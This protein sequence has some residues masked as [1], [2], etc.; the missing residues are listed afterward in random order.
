LPQ[1]LGVA[2]AIA[3]FAVVVVCFNKEGKAHFTFLHAK[4]GLAVFLLMLLQP[5]NAVF[6]PH[7]PEP[8]GG[9]PPVRSLWELLHKKMGYACLLAAWFNIILAF[10]LP[11][12]QTYR[13]F[14]TAVQVL[15]YCAACTYLGVGLSFNYG[16]LR[17]EAE[18]ATDSENQSTAGAY[19]TF[20]GTGP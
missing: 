1:V 2:A 3:G 20:Q 12:M 19:E 14:N 4:A 8:G 7:K 13:G 11:I 15:F 10:E 18:E 17:Q 9:T 6:R 16:E 5:L